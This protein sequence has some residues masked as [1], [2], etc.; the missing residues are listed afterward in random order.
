MLLHG[1]TGN[2]KTWSSLIGLLANQYSLITVDLLGHGL[3]DAP[4]DS[5]YY[6]MTETV[7]AL[8]EVVDYFDANEVIWLGYSMGARVALSAAV[9]LP[10]VTRGLIMESG[11]PGLQTHDERS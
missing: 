4:L 11:S 7:G 5:K 3:S 9:S 2:S 10:N 1:F 8:E 6:R